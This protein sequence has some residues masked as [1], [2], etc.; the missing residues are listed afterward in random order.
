MQ[1]TSSRRDCFSSA[2]VKTFLYML[3]KGLL[4]KSWYAREIAKLVYNCSDKLPISLRPS[5]FAC[6]PNRAIEIL[7]LDTEMALCS[8]SYDP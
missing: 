6:F 8:Q 7:T 1:G 2:A 5:S 3:C 4:L